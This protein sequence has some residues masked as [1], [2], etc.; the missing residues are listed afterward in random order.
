MYREIKSTAEIAQIKLEQK[1]LD[2]YNI[3]K[4]N[5]FICKKDIRCKKGIFTQGSPVFL[6]TDN[7]ARIGKV[8]DMTN[9]KYW[10]FDY[11]RCF[12]DSPEDEITSENLSEYFEYNQELSLIYQD[13]KRTEKDLLAKKHQCY[14]YEYSDTVFWVIAAGIAV[15]LFVFFTRMIVLFSITTALSMANMA[16]LFSRI[17][18]R[19]KAVETYEEFVETAKQ[20]IKEFAFRGEC[21]AVCYQAYA[22]AK[23]REQTSVE[24]T[25]T[26]KVKL[27]KDMTAS[28][29]TM[30]ALRKAAEY[31]YRYTE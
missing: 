14:N 21:R 9:W 27:L 20:D 12:D 26:P 19:K 4:D 17:F 29:I 5:A 18:K 28:E 7:H 15:P 31:E 16:C 2:L 25:K 13:K 10:E 30:D 22:D 3:I 8:Y 11:I 24:N 23:V 6:G 1:D